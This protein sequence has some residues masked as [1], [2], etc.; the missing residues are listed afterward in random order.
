MAMQAKPL[1]CCTWNYFYSNFLGI[2]TLYTQIYFN[3]R[4]SNEHC[5]YFG[6][7]GINMRETTWISTELVDTTMHSVCVP[8]SADYVSVNLNWLI[9]RCRYLL[10]R[11]P[12]WI[13]RISVDCVVFEY[14]DLKYTSMMTR[15]KKPNERTNDALITWMEKWKTIKTIY[16]LFVHCTK[17]EKCIG[18][19]C[20]KYDEQH[21][22]SIFLAKSFHFTLIG[23][24]CQIFAKCHGLSKI[25]I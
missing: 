12:S 14:L 3:F 20:I 15:H 17:S 4:I 2:C 9:V 24:V 16:C 18:W 10:F 19:N 1:C 13:C 8:V 23:C 22:Y 7:H 21:I 11:Q 25:L 5:V 6:L